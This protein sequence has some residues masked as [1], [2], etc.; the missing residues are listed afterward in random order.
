MEKQNNMMFMS[1][2]KK[3]TVKVRDKTVDLK[4]TN[5]RYCGLIVIAVSSR[6]IDQKNA[7]GK[8]EFTL[9]HWALFCTKWNHIYMHRQIQVDPSS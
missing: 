2:D 8:F 5:D 3:M 1:G 6:D 4:E 7:N 9:T